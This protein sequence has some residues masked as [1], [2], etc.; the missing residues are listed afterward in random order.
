MLL[1]D[2]D[3]KNIP[4]VKMLLANGFEQYK[5]GDYYKQLG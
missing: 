1:A 3:N 4:S 5:D 2:A